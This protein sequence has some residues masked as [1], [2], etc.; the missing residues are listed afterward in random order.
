ME[1]VKLKRRTL[2]P[3]HPALKHGGYSDTTLLPGEDPAAFEKLHNDLIKDGASSTLQHCEMP[4]LLEI[5]ITPS[6]LRDMK[7]SAICTWSQQQNTLT[8]RFE[9]SLET[10]SSWSTLEKELH[11]II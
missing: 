4:S 5:D 1:R 10:R 3:T 11:L 2:E 7:K 6:D 8:P 9:K